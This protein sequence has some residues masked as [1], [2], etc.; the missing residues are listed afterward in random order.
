M[1]MSA[2]QEGKKAGAGEV[3]PPMHMHYRMGAILRHHKSKGGRVSGWGL[4][5]PSGR[6]GSSCYPGKALA[7]NSEGFL[8]GSTQDRGPADSP[9]LQ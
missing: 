1:D 6:A 8:S 4:V 9:L 2:C 7:W 3:R 5:E